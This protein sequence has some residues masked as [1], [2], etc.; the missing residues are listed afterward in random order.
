[1]FL[2]KVVYMH[3]H[4]TMYAVSTSALSTKLIKLHQVKYL[5]Y[6][7]INFTYYLIANFYVIKRF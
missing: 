5:T 4:N 6:I 7:Y 3:M 2:I 1:M